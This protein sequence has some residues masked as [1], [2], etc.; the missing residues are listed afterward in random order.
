MILAWIFLVI[1]VLTAVV[2]IFVLLLGKQDPAGHAMLL[3]PVLIMV[4]AAAGGWVLLRHQFVGWALVV[5]GVPAIVALYMLYLS[6][7]RNNTG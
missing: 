3:L 6:F 2:L 4:A 7:P 5:T 1:D